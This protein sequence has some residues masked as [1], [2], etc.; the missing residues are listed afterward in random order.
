VH[1]PGEG[2]RAAIA[3]DLGGSQRIGLIVRA[4]AA[5]LLRKF[6]TGNVASRS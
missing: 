2:G 4:E 5:M 3:A 6:S 1:V